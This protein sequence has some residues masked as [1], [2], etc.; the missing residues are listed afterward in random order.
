MGNMRIVKAVKSR[1]V[2]AKEFV[3]IIET[4]YDNVES[5]RFVL[6]KI[7]ENSF[8]KFEVTFRDKELING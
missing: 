5:T 7:G 2:G 4:R 8:G 3:Q 6:P 1:T